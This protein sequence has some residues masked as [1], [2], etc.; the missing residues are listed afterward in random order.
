M[1]PEPL[2]PALVHFPIVLAMLA[3]LLA[4]IAFW[5]IQSGR[6]PGRVWIAIVILQIAVAGSAWLATE[7]GER[8]EERVERVVAERHIETHEEAAERF[9]ALAALGIPLAAAGLLAGRIGM[10][11]R[12][13]TIALSLGV[14]GAAGITGHSGGEL[15]YRHGAATAYVQTGRTP[16]GTALAQ[17]DHPD[18]RSDHQSDHRSDDDSDD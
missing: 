15:V 4:A 17:S 3:P 13:L 1:I 11:N 14:L 8:E 9:L 5:A 7:T 18:H 2:H 10:L 12:A 16:M 6:Q